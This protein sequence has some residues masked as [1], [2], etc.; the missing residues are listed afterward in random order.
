MEENLSSEERK[1]I[2]N[3]VRYW[4]MHKAALNGKEYQICDGI[5]KKWFDDVYTQK[6]EQA[7]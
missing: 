6:K 7:T 3:A 4:Q 2:F 1:L 5:L